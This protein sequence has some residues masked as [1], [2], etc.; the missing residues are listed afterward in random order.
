MKFGTHIHNT[1]LVN[2]V[3][4]QSVV[5]QGYLCNMCRGGE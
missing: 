1:K 3:K 4:Y 5:M 2:E